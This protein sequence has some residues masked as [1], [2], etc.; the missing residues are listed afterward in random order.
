MAR[1]SLSEFTLDDQLCFALYSA[2]RAMTAAYRDGLARLGLTYTQYV[3][4]LLLW[5]HGTLSMSR[6]GER[7]HLD[8]ATLSPVIKRMATQRLVTRRRSAHDERNV[9][10]TCTSTGHALR[11]RVRAVQAA[12]EQRS[13]LSGGE[14]ATMRADLHRLA[15]RLREDPAVSNWS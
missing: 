11:D 14:L 13:G 5:E 12:V 3:V 4:M 6:L 15:A 10:I 7:L 1:R 9:E 8:S 2:S